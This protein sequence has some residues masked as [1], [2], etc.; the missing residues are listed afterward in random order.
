MSETHSKKVAVLFGGNSAEREV[1]LRSGAAVTAGL[2][3]A[4]INAHGL[5]TASYDVHQLATDGFTHAFIALHGRGGED[6]VMQGALEQLAIPYTGSRVLGA[7]LAMDKIIPNKYGRLRGCQPR[8][9][10]SLQPVIL[11]P[12]LQKRLCSNSVHL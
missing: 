2:Q 1:S 7:A 8:Y 11:H 3:R 12:K 10:A 5:D 6:G 4:G 9:I